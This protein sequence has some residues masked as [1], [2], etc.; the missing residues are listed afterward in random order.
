MPDG[1][2]EIQSP[3]KIGEKTP[4][5]L[6]PDGFVRPL[7]RGVI[8]PHSTVFTVQEIMT[9]T[10]IIAK[11]AWRSCVLQLK[12]M[13]IEETRLIGDELTREVNIET[14]NCGT[15]TDWLAEHDLFL[16]ENTSATR[17]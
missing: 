8:I 14:R 10:E 9:G 12:G 2:I 15:I 3:D 6:T 16:N 1:D 5:E 11:G 4:L 17:A 7:F 13:W